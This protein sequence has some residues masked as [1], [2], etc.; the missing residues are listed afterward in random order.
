[1]SASRPFGTISQLRETFRSLIT[2]STPRFPV[3]RRRDP[4]TVLV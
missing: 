1:M 4:T 3:K 2:R